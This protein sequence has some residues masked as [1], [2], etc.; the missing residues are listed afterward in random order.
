[1]E[2]HLAINRYLASKQPLVAAN[3]LRALGITLNTHLV[4]CVGNIPATS[5]DQQHVDSF[6]QHLAEQAPASYNTH[7]SRLRVFIDWCQK[8]NIMSGTFHPDVPK[9]PD[10]QQPRT[11]IPM[12]DFPRLLDAAEHPR[13]RAA[14]AIGLHLLL[15]VSEMTSLRIRDLDL[16]GGL[17]TVTIEKTGDHHVMTVDRGL[18]VEL[19]RWLTAYTN[20]CGPLD[21]DWF[22]IPS[23]QLGCVLGRQPYDGLLIVPTKSP[24]RLQAP[25]Q[26]AMRKIGY[27]VLERREG[28]HTLRR[29]GARAFFDLLADDR[30][31][32]GAMRVVMA[33]LHHKSQ[34][35][36]ERYLGL[37][38]DRERLAKLMDG[39]Y[40]YPVMDKEVTQHG[41]ALSLVV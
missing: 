40:M 29:S 36:T 22:L 37:T 26:E 1:M 2:L 35:T 19:R 11:R 25:I 3:T 23:M 28:G 30:G 24:G 9:R 8:R 4:G 13:D 31:Y 27:P 16:E 39:K 38:A 15:R 12:S 32:D 14:I 41:D 7:M 6:A 5:F 21:P 20:E 10:P 18:D 17:I 33:L 34:Q